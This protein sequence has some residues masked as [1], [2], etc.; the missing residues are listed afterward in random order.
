MA[1]MDQNSPREEQ[2]AYTPASFEKRTAAWM[3]IAYMLMFL[4]IITFSLFCPDRSLAGTFPLFLVPVA[5]AVTVIEI[6]RAKASAEAKARAVVIT[7]LC[8]VV[9]A[10][11]LWMGVPVLA[12][13]LGG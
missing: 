13:A 5:V 1:D 4:F 8:V 6:H 10:A 9:A 7:F 3:G 11:A 12:A 2:P